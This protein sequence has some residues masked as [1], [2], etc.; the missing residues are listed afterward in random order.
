MPPLL[1]IVVKGPLVRHRHRTPA[2]G[3]T[4]SSAMEPDPAQVAEDEKAAAEFERQ[5]AKARAAQ[6]APT[7]AA[8]RFGQQFELTTPMLVMPFGVFRKYHLF[9]ESHTH[10]YR[11][12]RVDMTT[13]GPFHPVCEN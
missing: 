10:D 13:L 8:L 12:G 7:N 5:L 4:A 3:N 11:G 6:E 1:P 9:E 2:M